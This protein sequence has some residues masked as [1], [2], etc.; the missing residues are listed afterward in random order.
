MLTKVFA[1]TMSLEY[2][3]V[4]RNTH[5]ARVAMRTRLDLLMKAIEADSGVDHV[6]Y[7]VR[8]LATVFEATLGAIY[9]DSELNL[10]AVK[11]AIRSMEAWISIGTSAVQNSVVSEGRTDVVQNT[12]AKEE[13]L[14]VYEAAEKKK[15]A[16]VVATSPLLPYT[17][18]VRSLND[19]RSS[20]NQVIAS[21][22]TTLDSLETEADE[23]KAKAESKASLSTLRRQNRRGGAHE[24]AHPAGLQLEREQEQLENLGLPRLPPTV[25]ESPSLPGTSFPCDPNDLRSPPRDAITDKSELSPPAETGAEESKAHSSLGAAIAD[26]N[27]PTTSAETGAPKSKAEKKRNRQRRRRAIR[28]AK[29]LEFQREQDLLE[30]AGRMRRPLLASSE[31]EEEE[32]KVKVEVEAHSSLGAIAVAEKNK[33]PPSAETGA[34]ESKAKKNKNPSQRRSRQRRSDR[35]R[36]EAEFER[37]R[38][39]LESLRLE[40]EEFGRRHAQRFGLDPGASGQKAG[41]EVSIPPVEQKGTEYAMFHV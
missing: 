40:H 37:A 15:T 30:S 32:S 12:I 18:S 3:K 41:E 28:R 14:A 25:T 4:A 19:L 34:P 36:A 31:T 26:E 10:G 24:R 29:L 22:D 20:L 8:K 33:M 27:T 13:D 38:K 39:R 9:L 7:N 17:S 6:P 11:T 35:R 2:E 23:L 1:A 16:N 21:K 5:M